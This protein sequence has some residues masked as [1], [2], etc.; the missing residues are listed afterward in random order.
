MTFLSNLGQSS[1]C[2]RVIVIGLHST[3]I[4]LVFI[5]HYTFVSCILFGLRLAKCA[6]FGKANNNKGYGP[7]LD[8][9]SVDGNFYK[10]LSL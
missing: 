1:G 4:L 8:P 2:E 9:A 5:S 6:S 3:I 7:D 10:S